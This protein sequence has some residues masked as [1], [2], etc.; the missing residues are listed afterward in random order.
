MSAQLAPPEPAA[1]R[2]ARPSTPA[3][4]DSTRPGDR[5]PAP[6]D[7]DRGLSLLGSFVGALAIMVGDVVVIGAVG[8]SWILIPGGVVMV[9]M[10]LIVFAVIIRLLADTGENGAPDAH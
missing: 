7:P 8:E 2:A 4:P 9:L 10:T 3:P 5:G 6:R 1:A